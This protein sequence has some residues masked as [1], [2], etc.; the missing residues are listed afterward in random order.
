MFNK[1]ILLIVRGAIAVS[2]VIGATYLASNGMV[3]WGWLIFLAFAAAPG[4]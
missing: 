1:N 4:I 3:G 2:A